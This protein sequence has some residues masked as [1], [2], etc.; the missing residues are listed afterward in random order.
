[1]VDRIVEASDGNPLFVAELVRMLIDDGVLEHESAR[2]VATVDPRELEVPPS[3]HALLAAR[4]DRLTPAER[5]VVEAAAVIG[6]T[7][8]RGAL[9]TLVGPDVASRLDEHLEA[10]RRRELV[11]PDG[12][13]WVDRPVLRFHHVLIRDAAYRRLLK[14]DRAA[15][16]ERAAAWFAEHA[17]VADRD[18]L[19]GFHLEHAHLLR[20]ELGTA[21]LELGHRAA[22]HLASAGHRALEAEDVAVGAGL[23]GRALACLGPDG[24]GRAA[25]LLERCEALLALGEVA[26]A[27]PA[28]A[29]LGTLASGD[30][31][32]EGWAACFAGE[33]ANLR[34][35]GQLAD[36]ARLAADAAAT[37]ARLGDPAGE[38][39]AHAVRAASL[40]RLGRIG[41]SEEALDLA[42]AGARQAGDGRRATLILAEAP[43]A[44]LWGPNPITLATGRCLDVVRALRITG[45]SAAVEATSMRCQA[46]LEAL[47][48]R[49]E[50]ARRLLAAAR[51]SLEELGHDRGLLE[52]DVASGMVGILTGD[53]P[54]A[55]HALRRARAGFAGLGI[56]VEAALAA[57][58]LARV[59]LLEGDADEALRWCSESERSGGDD[60]KVGI[61]W[62]SARAE[63]LARNGE[64]EQA[65]KVAEE[66]VALGA[67]TDALV[68]H[69]DA[70]VALAEVLRADGD[71]E[72]AAARATS[73]LE[74]YERK[75]A[76]APAERA[77]A[78]VAAASTADLGPL[79]AATADL[80]AFADAAELDNAATRFCTTWVPALL[81]GDWEALRAQFS[82]GIVGIDH[83]A[84][85]GGGDPLIGREANLDAN[86][87]VLEVGVT[88]LR[89]K[90][91]E[92]AGE[93]C[94]LLRAE[95]SGSMGG[96]E[97]LQLLAV[98]REGLLLHSEV[99]DLEQRAAA[100]AR[101]A[102]LADADR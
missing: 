14:G 97:V 87:G 58:L 2:W 22:A 21:D 69:A 64:V 73:A 59:C 49:H 94:A 83:R 75:Q 70:L 65:R 98:D 30:A 15:L 82:E 72:G 28:V 71:V 74:L 34:N 13:Y 40:A 8:D 89:L 4:I 48:G 1:V 38:A 50:P 60:L 33:L 6:K 9:L 26:E 46:V 32:L 31:R 20:A 39:K 100:S 55:G 57:G 86:R 44:A 85:V 37:L 43:P 68:D 19:V 35:P 102:E 54:T 93:R 92:V 67:G 42:L 27:V 41:E 76:T 81:H 45:R 80:D 17:P 88:V 96:L 5:A 56:D 62:R 101:L 91:L 7:F 11:E 29:E 10:Q 47:R 16:H 3:I 24:P 61:T 23:L 66:A 79:E 84:L 51:A 63:A 52:V 77:R 78:L 12:S 95:Y 36:T 18:G 90:P 99:F 25:L 53:L